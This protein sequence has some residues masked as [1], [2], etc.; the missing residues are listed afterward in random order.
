MSYRVV[1]QLSQRH[2]DDLMELYIDTWW[3]GHRTREQVVEMLAH[4]SLVI[5][6][7]DDAS[8]KLVGFCRLLT[9]FVFRGTLYDVIAHPQHRGVGMG[10]AIMEALHAHP[11]VRRIEKL[12]LDCKPD[13]VSLYQ[14]WGWAVQD[15]TQLLHMT[16]R[17]D[18]S[19][20]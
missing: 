19:G 4:T 3:T 15:G 7:V 12:A 18:A 5:G 6:I 2:I 8:G 16:R 9:D 14:K 11:R 13:K 17:S 1:H 20:K 10:R